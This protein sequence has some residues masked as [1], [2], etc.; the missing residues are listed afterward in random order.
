MVRRRA[1]GNVL[2]PVVLPRLDVIG[3]RRERPKTQWQNDTA[4][5]IFDLLAAQ[6]VDWKV[7][8]E[9]GKTAT[10]LA[11]YPYGLTGLVHPE[12]SRKY[13]QRF[14]DYTQFDRDVAAGTL[15]RYAF[16]E[17]LYG[18]SQDFHPPQDIRRNGEEVLRGVYEAIRTSG[19]AGGHDYTKDTMLLVVFDEHGGTYDHV[20]PGP[21]PAPAPTPNPPDSDFDFRKLGVR[22]P[23]IAISAYTQAGTV[24]NTPV[25]HAAVIRTLRRKYGIAAPLRA[26]R[27]PQWRGPELRRQPGH[28]ASCGELAGFHHARHG[29]CRIARTMTACAAAPHARPPIGQ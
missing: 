16:V 9:K 6:N 11:D 14:V 20:A 5:T 19:N 27:G 13:P 2:Q 8:F 17:R 12:V 3:L 26:R 23:A 18:G 28:T 10:D 22:V 15:P 29:T 7:Y 25:H 24:I 1:V 4:P 21:A